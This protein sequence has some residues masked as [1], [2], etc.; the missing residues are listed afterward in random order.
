MK[1]LIFS[2]L[3]LN[4]WRSF[5]LSDKLGITKR[6]ND[7]INVLEQIKSI[8]SNQKI[9]IVIFGGDLFHSVGVVPVECLNIAYEFFN[10]LK[11]NKIIYY[12]VHG[13]HDLINR[14][15]PAWYQSA[16]TPFEQSEEFK[17]NL[18]IKC[19]N[20]NEK[21]NYDELIDFD[22][23]VLHK[24]PSIINEYNIEFEGADWNRLAAQNRLVFFGHW[25]TREIL[26]PNCI[27][28]GSVMPLSFGD[29]NERG[30]WIV[31]SEDW[32]P[33]FIEIDSPKFVT[34][35]TSNEIKL[36]NN[37]YRVL[38]SEKRIDNEN[39]VTIIEPKH[40]DERIKSSNFDEILNEW[41]T[42]NLKDIQIYK[43]VIREL[44]E[45]KMQ[46]FVKIFNGKLSKVKIQDFMSIGNIEFEIPEGLIFIS[47][48]SDVFDTNGSGKSTVCEAIFW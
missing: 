40:F 41:L 33:E 46:L 12:I 42:L 10:W 14:E 34:V 22:V 2:D 32:I 24:Q 16:V 3:H 36:D 8:I 21:I 35:E 31:D 1:I 5:G 9:D 39:V 13:N 6:L 25:H 44:L 20:W 27:I 19:I 48:R 26:L 17:T 45:D 23:L 15:T 4:T 29:C 38:H 18:K 30:I 7:Q 11:E 28:L 37:Y 43:N 47:G